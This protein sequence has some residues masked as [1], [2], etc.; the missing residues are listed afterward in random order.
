MVKHPPSF[1]SSNTK[2]QQDQ[3]GFLSQTCPKEENDLG[4][5]QLEQKSLICQEKIEG[6]L[7]VT[8]EG[9]TTM[10]HSSRTGWTIMSGT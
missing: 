10:V 9:L 3:E 6:S 1:T 7:V 4:W 8:H 5:V 2:V